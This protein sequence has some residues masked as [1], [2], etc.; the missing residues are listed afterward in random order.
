MS[1]LW[2]RYY[3]VVDVLLEGRQAFFHIQ[4]N[5]EPML[6]GVYTG[7]REVAHQSFAMHEVPVPQQWRVYQW[8]CRGTVILCRGLKQ[9]RPC[10]LT[11]KVSRTCAPKFFLRILSIPTA[12]F[13]RPHSFFNVPYFLSVNFLSLLL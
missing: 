7:I 2:E 12:F 9:R 1:M 3:C 8:A 4:I 6:A 10:K 11:P 5:A 13:Q